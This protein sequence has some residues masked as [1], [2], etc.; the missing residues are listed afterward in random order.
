MLQPQ[1]KKE[2]WGKKINKIE[3]E[4]VIQENRL[5]S[6]V[7]VDKGEGSLSS[8]ASSKRNTY[9]MYRM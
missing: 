7:P 6:R 9:C 3:Q 4:L 5:H 2:K 8:T 1:E